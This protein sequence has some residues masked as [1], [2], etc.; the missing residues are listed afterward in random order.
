MKKVGMIVGFVAVLGLAYGMINNLLSLE[1]FGLASI[2]VISAIYGVYK[3]FE[4]DD[5]ERDKE[6]AEMVLNAERVQSMERNNYSSKKISDILKEKYQLE[7]DIVDFRK[8]MNAKE[9]IYKASLSVKDQMIEEYQNEHNAI[10]DKFDLESTKHQIFRENYIK[11]MDSKEKQ[12]I[13][14]DKE[15]IKL[16]EE[17]KVL[18]FEL[19][20]MIARAGML[21]T[22]KEEDLQEE[23]EDELD[24]MVSEEVYFKQNYT[25]TESEP[26]KKRKKQTGK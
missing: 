12:L 17:V 26:K 22:T 9:G 20:A 25:P 13:E 15:L 1:A 10:K 7:L 16:K 18:G 2:A 19:D 24:N 5:L 14:K 23:F 4:V 6:Q 8:A 3:K 21:T 11:K